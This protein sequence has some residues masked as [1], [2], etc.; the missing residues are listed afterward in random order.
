[1]M[2]YQLRHIPLNET[3]T[4]YSPFT[5]NTI[6]RIYF[7]FITPWI[8]RAVC[9]NVT[10][11][12][13][14]FRMTCTDNFYRPL[15]I[16]VF[17]ILYLFRNHSTLVDVLDG[18]IQSPSRCTRFFSPYYPERLKS[19]AQPVSCSMGILGPFPR[20]KVSE[21]WRWQWKVSCEH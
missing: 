13:S 2:H 8:D 7:F 6:K 20:G 5:Y 17:L 4:L 21:V 12:E 10:P 16:N 11:S 18:V 1:M 15:N 3:S 19:P 9:G 14:W